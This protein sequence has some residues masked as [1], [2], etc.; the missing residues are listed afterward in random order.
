[1]SNCGHSLISHHD[2]VRLTEEIERYH[3]MIHPPGIWIGNASDKL[4]KN[5]QIVIRVLRNYHLLFDLYLIYHRS[6]TCWIVNIP[7]QCDCFLLDTFI[8]R[9]LLSLLLCLTNQNISKTVLHGRLQ[10]GQEFILTS[11]K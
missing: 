8:K 5:A 3:L 2:F 11:F 10:L 7:L 4:G 1:M 6:L 9:N